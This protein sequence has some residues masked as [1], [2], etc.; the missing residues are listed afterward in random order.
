VILFHASGP[1]GRALER[2]AGTGEL[3]GVV[4]LTT[5]ELVDLI[6]GGVYSAGDQRMTAAGQAGL[7]QVI[8]P[9]ALDHSNFWAGQVPEQF[10]DREFFQYNEQNILMRTNRQEYE[11]LAR[12]MS[13]RL[14]AATGRVAVLIPTQG[15]S[16]HTSR[17]TFDLNGNPIG[18]WHQPHAD[19]RFVEVLGNLLKEDHLKQF[20]MHINDPEFADIC[21]DTF[22]EMTDGEE[23]ARRPAPQP[24]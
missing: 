24:R 5:H 16:E 4:D 21:A 23:S 9:G 8:V 15:F 3:S 12:L 11:A 6:V 13:E 18:N 2:L 22:L 14:N 10:R 7:P 19:A 17:P 1:G 20:D